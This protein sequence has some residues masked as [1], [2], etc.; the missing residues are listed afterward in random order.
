METTSADVKQGMF[1]PHMLL[2]TQ[3][4]AFW[5]GCA[6]VSLRL[7]STVR[8]HWHSVLM[9]RAAN[10]IWWLQTL[11]VIACV[12]LTSKP[13]QTSEAVGC[14]WFCGRLC[15]L[16]HCPLFYYCFSSTLLI[17]F[18]GPSAHPAR[19][20]HVSCLFWMFCGFVCT[21]AVDFRCFKSL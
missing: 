12:V 15:Q 13:A 8:V 9:Y 4:A 11:A 2:G 14:E 18:S 17:T 5:N 20:P 7:T 10:I 1:K 21:F 3:V 16:L 6:Q 19:S